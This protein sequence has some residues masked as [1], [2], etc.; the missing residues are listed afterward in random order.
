[1]KK[2]YIQLVLGTIFIFLSLW[3]QAQNC[4]QT[5]QYG[6][7]NVA[8]TG[9][10]NLTTCNYGGEFSVNTFSATGS[11]TITSSIGTDYFTV[12][13]NSNNVVISG[14]SPL[15]V[16]IPSVGIYRIHVSTNSSCGTQSSCRSINVNRVI[17]PCIQTSQFPGVTVNIASQGTTNVTT[18]NFAGEFSANSFSA[19]GA[20]TI[21]SSVTTDF[22]T[23]TNASNNVLISGPSP[24]SVVIPSVGIYRIHVSSNSSC[25]TNSSCRSINVGGSPPPAVANDLCSGAILLSVPSGTSGTTVGATNEVPAPP[26]CVTGVQTTGG[27]WYRVTGNGN[28]LGADLCSGASASWDSKIFVFTGTCGTWNCVT[29]NDDF[30]PSCASAA[31]SATWCSIPGVNYFILVQGYSGPSNFS[32]NITQTVNASNPTLTALPSL[33]PSLCINSTATIGISGAST[34]SWNTAATTSVISLTPTANVNYTVLGFANGYGTSNC[35]VSTSVISVSTLPTPTISLT[36]NTAS[37]CPGGSVVVTPS[38]A[39][40][41]SYTT[42]STTLTGLSATL[43][44]IVSSIFT[45]SGTGSNG[46]RSQA[47]AAAN[48]TITTLASPTLVLSSSPAS[49]CPGVTSTLSVSGA[50]T[51]TWTSPAS[52]ATAVNVNPLVTT[53]YTVSGTGTTI[54]NGVNTITLTVFPTPTIT[55]N[56][57]SIC[58]GYSLN[59][60]PSGAS[61]YTIT[62]PTGTV[63]SPVS[64]MSTTN[65]TFTGTSAQGCNTSSLSSAVNTVVVNASPTISTIPNTTLCLLSSINLLPTGANTYSINGVSTTT[66]GNVSPAVTTT[67]VVTGTGTNNC[68]SPPAFSATDII[69]IV[70]LPTITAVSSVSAI[71][72]GQASTNLTASGANTYTWS[73]S[74]TGSNVAVSPTTSTIYTV[75]G[76]STL[77]C[78]NTSTVALTVLQLPNVSASSSQNF[79]CVGGNTS[80]TAIGANTY[81]WSNGASSSIAVV[82][83][84]VNAS[85]LVTGTDLNGCRNTA[86]VAITV[87][88]IVINVLPTSTTVC[89]GNSVTFTASG[90]TSYTWN[91][92]NFFPTYFVT[93]TTSTSYTVMA[94][95]ANLCPQMRTVLASV[96]QLPNVT[97]SITKTLICLNESAVLTAGG[98]NT[99]SWSNGNTTSSISVSPTIDVT[100][101]YTVVG[102][103]TNNCIAT[104]SQ[105]LIVSKC[106][107]FEK[108]FSDA[109]QINVYPNPSTGVFNVELT[110]NATKDIQVIDLT[111]RIIYAEK[112]STN[113]LSLNLN[114]YP[115]GIYYLKVNAENAIKTIKL[116]KE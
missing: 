99:Y 109:S 59:L 79:I 27:V 23:I 24:L 20:Y 87:N 44:P 97:A 78:N 22:L 82:N 47:S 81:S 51:Y 95:D 33:T 50:N 89:L 43:N 55:V 74:L 107:G 2:N 61:T 76:T 6:G 13:D 106:T 83:P 103:D 64:P 68:I 67:Y 25:G 90:A 63:N 42:G 86:S 7:A 32:I 39:S 62:G 65:Y 8:S 26:T 101:Y 52:N 49:V 38:G 73:N 53:V 80:L 21:Y 31:A 45:I 114:A 112:T 10:T 3:T 35:G 19:A 69:T 34:Y 94:T 84:S 18:C 100:Y 102:T 110:S 93:P 113:K 12:T 72:I 116:I 115:A 46:C 28:Q 108:T 92:T 5:S 66:A 75:T 77:L 88:T 104:A 40:S 16:T 85:Y 48:I 17:P 54:C 57:G 56:S 29:G 4:I 30:G 41:Y 37:I 91:G 9:I 36:P 70:P 15:A 1:M 58:G 98:A 11:Y 60:N 96:Y 71:C 105:S 14:A 111:G